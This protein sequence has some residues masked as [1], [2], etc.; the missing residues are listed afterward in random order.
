V[1]VTK[2]ASNVEPLFSIAAMPAAKSA[3]QQIDTLL[4][5]NQS[6][7]MNISPV[8]AE[9]MLEQNSGNRP[10]NRKHVARL[11]EAMKAGDWRVTG[12]PVIFAKDGTLNDGQH[13]LRAVIESGMTIRTD[14]RFGV[15]R[16]AFV[17]T[18]IGNKRGAS[19]ALHIAGEKNSSLLASAIRLA[20]SF[21][22][23]DYHFKAGA[24]PMQV[25]E[26]LEKSPG[27]RTAAVKADR[28]RTH[29]KPIVP[30][31][32][33]FTYHACA[34]ISPHEADIFFERLATG[35]DIKRSSDPIGTARRY[36]I[37]AANARGTRST[38]DQV[39]VIFKAWNAW[40]K[41]ENRKYL[42]LRVDGAAESFPIPR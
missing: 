22:A 41:G 31:V 19:D 3:R 8:M 26:A 30:S 34:A 24:S 13:R 10:V 37:N 36:F 25:L 15:E 40:R 6:M 42:R 11:A 23:G 39:A 20:I 21:G 7:T 33:A 12:Q 2:K 38:Q 32:Y 35:V 29:F 4:K 28:W 14:V 18:D 16:D 9:V 17:V 27:F 5:T 1:G